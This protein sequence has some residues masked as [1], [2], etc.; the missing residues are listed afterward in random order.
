[1]KPPFETSY[2]IVPL[3]TKAELIQFE[4]T[5]LFGNYLQAHP[6]DVSQLLTAKNKDGF[7]QFSLDMHPTQDLIN[8][9]AMM[10]GQVVVT[11]PEWL[12]NKISSTKKVSIHTF[13]DTEVHF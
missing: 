2:N 6:V 11:S 12:T 7:M 13:N 8:Y 3:T 10:N 5:P 4:T 9:F 1:V